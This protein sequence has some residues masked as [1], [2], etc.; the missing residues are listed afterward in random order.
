MTSR[1]AEID[2][3]LSMWIGG[4]YVAPTG[5]KRAVNDPYAEC[6]FADVGDADADAVHRAV[7]H[8]KEAQ[9]VW[10]K[11]PPR[12]RAK[13]LHRVAACLREQRANLVRAE[14]LNAGVPKMLASRFSVAAAIRSFEYFAEWTDKIYGEVVPINTPN[15]LDFTRREPVGV[16]AAITAWNT[17]TLFIG[18]KI[19][20]ALAAGNAVVIKPSELAPLPAYMFSRAVAEAGLPA[21]LIN[22]I[23]GGAQT[24]EAL[25]RHPDVDLITFTGGTAT[26]ERIAASA[27]VKRTAFELGG[28]SAADRVRRRQPGSGRVSAVLRKLRSFRPSVCGVLAHPRRAH[29]A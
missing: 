27:G 19:A 20:P 7:S 16:V 17:P 10:A 21:G 15:V 13:A 12:K 25:V 8:A 28:K 18:S 14:C 24:G 6:A 23:Y 4:E 22:V 26:G 11:T 2:G 9:A 1:H 3:C 29:R 5:D